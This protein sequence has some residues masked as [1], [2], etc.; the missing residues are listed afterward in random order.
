[1]SGSYQIVS[2]ANGAK[3]LFSAGYGEKMHPGLGPMAEAEILCVRQLRIA[4]RMATNE[5]E[6][7]IWD[8]GL[9]AAANATAALR[10]RAKFPAGCIWPASTTRP[11][12]L[13]LR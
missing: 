13:N 9:G 2:L 7:V 4:E 6:F 3:T 11:N 12:R 1:M 10:E 8:V 5:G